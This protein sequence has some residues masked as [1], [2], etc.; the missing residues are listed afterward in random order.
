MKLENMGIAISV[1][2]VIMAFSITGVSAAD[3]TQTQLT[4]NT[5]DDYLPF[6]DD[7]GN[8]VV[9]VE[10]V[11]G[12]DA[13]EHDREIL[14]IDLRTSSIER[15]TENVV[16]ETRPSI[17]G[18]GS[19]IVYNSKLEGDWEIFIMNPDGSGVRQLTTTVSGIDDVFPQINSDASTIVYTSVN[20]DD[21]R[22]WET[23]EIYVMNADGSGQRQLT[24][25]DDP[26]YNPVIGG[27]T[28]VFAGPVGED[29]FDNYELFVSDVSGR[30]ST[31]TNNDVRDWLPS[32]SNDGSRVAMVER[33]IVD[34]EY[35]NRLTVVN[36]DGT[37]L[38]R[39][40]YYSINVWD[41]C[42]SGD[43]SK[44]AF[45]GHADGSDDWEI[46]I[47]NYDGTGL[48]QLTVNDVED[49]KPSINYDG[50]KIVYHSDVGGDYEIFLL[51]TAA[52]APEV[53]ELASYSF[54]SVE[55]VGPTMIFGSARAP[56]GTVQIPV[57]L[58]NAE[59]IG[60]M[61]LVLTYDSSVL[62]A[63]E[64][65]KGSLTENS[66]MQ[67][68]IVDGTIRIGAIDVTGISGS[69]SFVN[70]VFEVIGTGKDV[71]SSTSVDPGLERMAITPTGS[72]LVIANVGT[73]T[74]DGEPVSITTIDGM[75]SYGSMMGDCNRDGM[76]TSV[77][78]L[79][80]L[81]MS[82]GTIPEDRVADIDGDGTVAAFDSLEIMKSAVHLPSTIRMDREVLR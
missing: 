28:I 27:D 3:W 72:E 9:F 42:I 70:V 43:G 60:S 5:V 2:T 56:S 44:I 57:T 7:R 58:S 46:Y 17:S 18:D 39:P 21:D 34:S 74:V 82:I 69:G 59:D 68:N 10:D 32:I 23:Q 4:S 76:I 54:M 30:P 25:N 35:Y 38:R 33:E 81:Q 1:L 14:L 55:P 80:A 41:P 40:T 45:A 26:E 71:R 77:D 78:A 29:I 52:A 62:R 22:Y 6:I 16:W 64:V 8:I 73:R 67:S 47:I 79:M 36:S 50:S 31:L 53:Y 11:D 48:T 61:D 13:T 20:S 65:R 24:N 15:L 75:F 51:S 66:I 12:N 49:G 19:K 63:T 37:E